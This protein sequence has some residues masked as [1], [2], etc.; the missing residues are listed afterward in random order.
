MGLTP[1]PDYTIGYPSRA[2][3]LDVL[4]GFLTP[5]AGYGEVAFYWWVGDPLTRERLTWQLDQ[6]AGKGVMGLQINYAHSDEG[7]NSYGLTYPSDP[8][9]FSKAWWKLVQWFAGEARKRGMAISLSDYTL[10]SVGQGQWTDEVLKENPDLHGSTLEPVSWECTGGKEFSVEV[11]ERTVGVS[12]WKTENGSAVAES[13]ID[14][15]PHL[16][17][18]TLRWQAPEGTWKVVAVRS[19]VQ[20]KSIDPLDPRTGPKVIEKFF[21]RFEDKLPGEAGKALNFFFSDELEFGIRKNLWHSR[22]ADE[23]KKR[24]GYDV[25]PELP[26]LFTDIGPRTPKVRLDFN[27]VMVALEEESFF[28][29]VLLWH[30]NRG[31][32]YGGDHGG[33]GTDVTEFGDYFRTQRWMNGPGNDQP[34]LGTDV[35]KTKVHSSIA[36]L[37]QQP[38][39]WLEGYHS[40]GW[41]TTPS[42]LVGAGIEN[43]CLGTTLQTFHGLYYTTHGGFWEWAPPCN[44]FRMPYWKHMGTLMTWSQRLCYLLSQGVHRCDVAI[45]YP[46]APMQAETDGQK[47]VETAFALASSLHD[48][49]IDFDFIDD[50]SLE[51]ATVEKGTLNVSGESYRALVLPAMATVHYSTMEQAKRLAESGGLVIASGV[52][53]SASDRIGRNDAEGIRGVVPGVAKSPQGGPQ[54]VDGRLNPLGTSHGLEE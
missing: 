28:K 49:G 34:N 50:Q 5:P 25:V 54:L 1:P 7:G 11:P 13:V 36:H 46:V 19:Q 6:L 4:P 44:H 20:M 14:L 18:R 47:S 48:R 53:P 45:L 33:R 3:D 38:R 41:G 8:P 27:D 22:F 35:I 52:L 30:H 40:S 43:Y 29:P 23:F 15:R 2:A 39:T 21:Q 9:L 24:K 16:Q 26:A 37:Y 32:I 17:G 51:R 12:A 10:S 31:M 42:Q